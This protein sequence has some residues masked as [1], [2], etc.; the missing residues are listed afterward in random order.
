MYYSSFIITMTRTTKSESN[1]NPGVSQ[2]DF[3]N[4]KIK[5][6]QFRTHT[7]LILSITVNHGIKA[8]T[9][10]SA[11][12]Y[13]CRCWGTFWIDLPAISSVFCDDDNI[14][15]DW[16]KPNYCQ[17]TI[18]HTIQSC[19]AACTQWVAQR[20]GTRWLQL[21]VEKLCKS[22]SRLQRLTTRV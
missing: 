19:K 22:P 2:R 11:S 3:D 9:M 8:G 13:A 1:S 20:M 12:L 5:P 10:S 15:I 17:R 4:F 7:M 16:P 6:G 21:E 14:Q 18:N